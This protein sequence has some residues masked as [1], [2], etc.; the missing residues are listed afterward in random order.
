MSD[1]E[2][3]FPRSPKDQI[4]GLPYFLRMCHKIRQ[5]AA[6]QLHGDYLPNLGKGLDLWTC[7]LLLVDYADLVSFIVG[8]DADDRAAL[9][10]CYE[11]GKKPE[12][13]VK[14][15]WCS[16]VRNR[17]FNDDLSERL[18][19]RKNDAGMGHLTELTSFIDF[20]DAEEGR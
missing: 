15:W 2:H 18:N 7:Q 13:P 3:S 14:D 17:G 6:G 1:T 10:W 20:I 16:Y 19:Q 9:D 5:N 4:D 11:N 8:S 12:S